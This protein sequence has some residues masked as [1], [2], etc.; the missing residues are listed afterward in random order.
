MNETIA[1]CKLNATRETKERQENSEH[2][3]EKYTE[4]TTHGEHNDASADDDDEDDVGDD[5]GGFFSLSRAQ[6]NVQRARW[7]AAGKAT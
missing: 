4:R 7:P 1:R 2:E 3:K 5:V 6:A